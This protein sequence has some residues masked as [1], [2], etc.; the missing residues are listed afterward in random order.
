MYHNTN[1]EDRPSLLLWLTL[2]R[3]FFYM[4]I[5]KILGKIFTNSLRDGFYVD[6]YFRQLAALGG[7]PLLTFVLI[8][9]NL[10]LSEL[11]QRLR[12]RKEPSVWP[13]LR[14]AGPTFLTALFVVLASYAWG[15]RASARINHEIAQST[16]IFQFGVIQGNIGDFEKVAAET[17]NTAAADKILDVFTSLSDQALS[18]L[19]RPDFLV[20][21]ETTYP[22]VFRSPLSNRE[23]AR[24]QRVENFVNSNGVPLLFGGYDRQN[25]KDFNSLFM[26]SPTALSPLDLQVYHKHVLL[27][28][29]EYIPL[30]EDVDWIKRLFPQMGFFGRGPGPMVFTLLSPDRRPIRLS[31]IICYEAL[32]PYFI[33]E[34]AKKDTQ[35][36]LN[37]TNDSWFGAY[38]EPYLHLALTVFRS[39]ESRLPQI[40]ATNT[41]ISTL[42]LPNGQMVDQSNMM[43]PEV[44]SY[45]VP[46]IPKHPTLM[47][48]WGDWF[49]WFCALLATPLLLFS[50]LIIYR[51][52]GS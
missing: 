34:A 10:S 44:R 39:I 21:P 30:M 6:P 14:V 46:L 49:G 17:G 41:G 38:G 35:L 23:L 13:A 27:P 9:F 2:E 42:I 50:C 32:F 19:P 12:L 24:D 7:V 11:I 51:K 3:A 22:A 20:W 43:V 37:V 26:L 18:T 31:P 4:T 28:F 40:R 33:L 15:M 47:T 16:E 45:R 25:D 29:G 52:K 5:E 36:I 1:L 48:M 8:F